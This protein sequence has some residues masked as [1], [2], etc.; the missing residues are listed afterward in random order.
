VYASTAASRSEYFCSATAHPLTFF[1]AQPRDGQLIP[2]HRF[3]GVP[4][5]N[6]G[7]ADVVHQ[8]NHIEYYF[9]VAV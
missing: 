9:D 1:S 2:T 3:F 6:L 7:L 5:Q 8:R 4:L